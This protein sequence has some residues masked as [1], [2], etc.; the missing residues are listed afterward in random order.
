M[1]SI[2]Q[3]RHQ[4]SCK[5]EGIFPNEEKA[6]IHQVSFNNISLSKWKVFT[7]M[8]SLCPTPFDILEDDIPENILNFQVNSEDTL[9]LL[10]GLRYP[11]ISFLTFCYF[12]SYL[13]DAPLASFA[14]S[15]ALPHL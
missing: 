2:V 10:N 8:T 11:T 9:I 12:S 14:D 1:I 3:T 13:R 7:E 4:C 15:F 5:P 6:V